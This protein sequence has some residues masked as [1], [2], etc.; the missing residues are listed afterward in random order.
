MLYSV[1]QLEINNICIS[2]DSFFDEGEGI[3]KMVRFLNKV[4]EL[5]VEKTSTQIIILNTS[6]QQSI[7]ICHKTRLEGIFKYIRFFFNEF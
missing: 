5:F 7:F 2:I 3:N 6:T 1:V 4:I